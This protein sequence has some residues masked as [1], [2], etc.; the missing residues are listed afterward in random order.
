MIACSPLTPSAEVYDQERI[1]QFFEEEF[2]R[3]HAKYELKAMPHGIFF[4]HGDDFDA[5]HVRFRNIARGGVRVV[6]AKDRFGE[7]GVG[8]VGGGVGGRGQRARR[9]AR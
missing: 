5:F 2:H 1:D 7:G 4:L 9:G 6:Q 3:D 8:G